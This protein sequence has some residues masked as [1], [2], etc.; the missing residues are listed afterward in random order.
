MHV[1]AGYLDPIIAVSRGHQSVSRGQ[2]PHWTTGSSNSPSASG[3]IEVVHL[4]NSTFTSSVTSLRHTAAANGSCLDICFALYYFS[5]SDWSVCASMPI[6]V[7]HK[8]CEYHQDNCT[9]RILSSVGGRQKT[10]Q[11]KH[12]KSEHTVLKGPWMRIPC[13]IQLITTPK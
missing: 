2:P 9:C 11:K 1:P 7:L 12:N 10:K 3:S 13:K 6:Y 5:T 8:L 4:S